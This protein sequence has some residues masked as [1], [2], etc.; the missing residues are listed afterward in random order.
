MGK[1]SMNN[2]KTIGFKDRIC[3]GNGGADKNLDLT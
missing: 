1:M 3:A 2:N